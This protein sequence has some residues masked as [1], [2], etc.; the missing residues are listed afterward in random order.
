MIILRQ[1]LESDV[2][3][4]DELWRKYWSRHSFPN[5][6]NRIID[7]VAID[8]EYKI[9]GYGQVKLFAEAMMFLDPTVSKRKRAYALKRLM[10]EAFRGCD[11]ASI[12]ELYAFIDDPKFSGLIQKRYGFK[13]VPHDGDLLLRKL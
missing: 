1:F 5:R 10:L 2:S 9:I 13:S 11:E 3:Q 4:L 8:E 7:A 6:E 12:Q